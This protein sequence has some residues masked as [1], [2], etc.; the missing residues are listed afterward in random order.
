MRVD[1]ANAATVKTA[2]MDELHDF[3]MGHDRRLVHQGVVG[4]QLVTGAL[5]PDQKLAEDEI[6]S[7][8]LASRTEVLRVQRRTA[9]SDGRRIQ[10]DVSTRTI[11]P[12]AWRLRAAARRV[13]GP[14][15]LTS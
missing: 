2:L 3:V 6:V 10:T 8:D 9:R 7:A 13:R 1:P 12:P 5:I 11:R 4:K 14:R 15:F